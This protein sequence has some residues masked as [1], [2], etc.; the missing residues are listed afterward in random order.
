MPSKQFDIDDHLQVTVHK[1]RTSRSIR[2]TVKPDGAV[3]VSIPLWASYRSALA[4]A[5]DR[6]GWIDAH[7]RPQG[8]LHEGQ[9]IGKAHRVYFVMRNAEFTIASRVLADKILI[10]YP[11]TMTP[12]DPAVQAAAEA[13]AEKAL[14]R[15][16][17]ALLP[18]R[19]AALAKQHSF[20]YSSMS[21]KKLKS[22][23][24]S[25]DSNRHI[26]FNIFLM[27]LEDHLIDYVILHELTHT[28]HLNHG[29]DFW[30]R[31]AE[32]CPQYKWLRKAVH[33]H[34]PIIERT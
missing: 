9:V 13:A 1:R 31:M 12:E 10:N 33:S 32:V 21:V 29:P 4:F 34:K 27:Q 15:Q 6:R 20:N 19:L 23:W 14:R 17:M 16:A 11:N 28:Q 8:L 30:Q 26:V 24:G 18:E 5:Q 2:L 7:S 3:H 25:C 22:R